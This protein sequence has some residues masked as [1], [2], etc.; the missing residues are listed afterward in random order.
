[1]ANKSQLELKSLETIRFLTKQGLITHEHSLTI[2][3]IKE[4]CA[5]WYKCS[6][7]TQRAAISKEI[8]AAI[9]LLPKPEIKVSDET[10][11]F[12]KELENAG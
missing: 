12:F 3:L 8:R 7:S 4:L 2:A 11:D 1:M 5:E 6:S 9:E 10:E